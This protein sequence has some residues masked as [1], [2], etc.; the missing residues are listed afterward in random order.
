MEPEIRDI[1][2][3]LGKVV[4]V[5][6]TFCDAEGNG[7]ENKQFW[8]TVMSLS[9]HGWIEIATEGKDRFGDGELLEIPPILE[10]ANPGTYR[11]HSTGETVVNPD[12]T[13]TWEIYP[14]DSESETSA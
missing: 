3:Y 10:A 11:L 8:G 2:P 7:I 6:V 5:G 4:L 9:K 12:F 1:G 13:C 14:P